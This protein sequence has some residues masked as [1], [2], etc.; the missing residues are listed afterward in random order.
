MVNYKVWNIQRR[1]EYLA[2]P[3]KKKRLK[4]RSARRVGLLEA[5]IRK[6]GPAKAVESSESA[7]E[8]T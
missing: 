7:P 1:H 5:M 4:K 2:T 3:A 6:A 8:T